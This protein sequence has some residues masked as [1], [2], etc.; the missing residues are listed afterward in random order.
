MKRALIY[1]FDFDANLAQFPDDSI[2]VLRI[3]VF[4]FE[5][6]LRYCGGDYECSGFDSIP[7]G[8]MRSK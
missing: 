7:Q 4:D 5:F 8:I 3:A 6:A 1:F 2:A